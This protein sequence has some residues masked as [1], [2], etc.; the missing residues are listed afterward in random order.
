MPLRESFALPFIALQLFFIRVF[1]RA[2][3][4]NKYWP[5]VFLAFFFISSLAVALTWQFAQFVFLLEACALISLYAVRLISKQKV[6]VYLLCI[7]RN[8]VS[9][10]SDHEPNAVLCWSAFDGV[11]VAVLQYDDFDFPHIFHYHIHNWC[12][13]TPGMSIPHIMPFSYYKTVHL[14]GSCTAA[15]EICIIPYEVA[16]GAT[17][18]SYDCDRNGRLH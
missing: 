14:L 1:L 12:L 15:E 6:T 13:H 7:P 4:S 17:V 11:C 10:Y 16:L 2:S 9:I 18:I 8:S 5:Q 3:S